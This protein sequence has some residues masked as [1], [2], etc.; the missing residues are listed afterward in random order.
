MAR[1]LHLEANLLSAW[2]EGGLGAADS[3]RVT[4]HLNHCRECRRIAA[5]AGILLR[6]AAPPR[7]AVRSW[8]PTL[9]LAASLVLVAGLSWPLS[10]P[11]LLTRVPAPPAPAAAVALPVAAPA[12][13]IVPAARPR[14]AVRRPHP[15]PATVRRLAAPVLAPLAPSPAPPIEVT[16]INFPPASTGFAD[17]PPQFGARQALSAWG[18]ATRS[19][20]L[21][22][23]PSLASRLSYAS[24]DPLDFSQA[25]V[26]GALNPWGMG[27]A[28]APAGS[29]PSLRIAGVSMHVETAVGG[30]LWAASRNDQVFTSADHGAHWRAVTLPS[31]SAALALVVSITFQNAQDGSIRDRRGATWIT[32]DGGTTWSRQ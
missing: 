5:C 8:L 28:G 9:A 21:A 10:R 27:W 24:D 15:A 29:A 4:A 2:L 23:S 32:R 30:V 20:P 18:G 1:E 25:S 26:G 14:P 7:P 17:Q 31:A 12:A 16:S 3:R 19:L 6:D 13:A 22:A 11:W